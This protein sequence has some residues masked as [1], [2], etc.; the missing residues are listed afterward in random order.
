M[1]EDQSV[2]QA[3]PGH[4]DASTVPDDLEDGWTP[5]P[6]N[7]KAQSPT[8]A[9]SLSTTNRAVTSC[10]GLSF[11]ACSCS[12]HR[13]SKFGTPTGIQTIF[14]SWGLHIQSL[15][16]I[17]P[18]CSESNCQRSGS[19]YF[20][21]SYRF[22]TWF[23]NRAIHFLLSAS[24]VRG[25]QLSLATTRIVNGRSDLFRF[26]RKNSLLDVQNLFQKGLASPYDCCHFAGFTALH[27]AIV[28]RRIEICDFLLKHGAR[29]D[30]QS[31][32]GV[33]ATDLVFT[34][35]YRSYYTEEDAKR[36]RVL[37]DEQTWLEQRS[38]TILHKLVVGIE[39]FSRSLVDELSTTTRD[40]D[41]P[42]AA[43]R[44]PFSCM[45]SFFAQFPS[46]IACRFSLLY[47]EVL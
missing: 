1:R 42:D 28:Y 27:C 23:V 38:L 18:P 10:N 43:G 37:F 11:S 17:T 7:D 39:G 13:A 8:D 24:R 6:C 44:T 35:I 9:P 26:V 45:G 33:T 22:P 14:G 25:P 34:R 5:D 40:I 46:Q 16:F 15:P 41:T 21:V 47:L 36:L 19:S 29:C 2:V 30:I 4:L 31:F 3:Y 12:C 32:E 20:E